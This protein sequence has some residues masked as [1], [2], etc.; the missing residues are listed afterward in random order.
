MPEII[1]LAGLSVLLSLLAVSGVAGDAA[2]GGPCGI[3]ADLVLTKEDAVRLQELEATRS[4]GL[5]Q[6]LRLEN[7]EERG[8]IAGLFENGFVPIPAPDAVIGRYQCRT[9]KLGG[10]LPGT[11][12]GWFAC[13]IVPEDGALVIRKATGSQ[14]FAGILVS[15]GQGLTYRG[16]LTYGYEDTYVL[17]GEDRERDQVGCLSALGADMNHFVLEMPRPVFESVHDVIELRRLD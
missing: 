17:Y 7:G 2:G 9:I 4:M 6:A 3:G 5:A 10:N 1:R 15:A 11:V 16:A 13:D 12:Y 8:V 14:K